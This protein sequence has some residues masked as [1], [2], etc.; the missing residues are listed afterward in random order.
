MATF[1]VCTRCGKVQEI[2]AI[3][4]LP[5]SWKRTPDDL[6]CSNCC[7]EKAEVPFE[8][9]LDEEVLYPPNSDRTIDETF[10]EDDTFCEVCTGPCQGH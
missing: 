3:D 4:Q 10:D 9:V 8:D 5:E 1:V 7:P 2:D 6:V